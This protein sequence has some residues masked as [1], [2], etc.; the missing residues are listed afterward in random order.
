MLMKGLTDIPGIRVGHVSDFEA[1]TGCT[2]IL[3]DLG[4]GKN[5]VHPGLAM[6]EAAA[7]AASTDAVAEGSVGAGTGAT[8]G[9]LFGRARAMKG[10][11]GSYTVT[12]PG[13]VMVSALCAVN[14]VGDV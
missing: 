4:M 13:G 10:G 2:A 9:K 11:V 12:L 8:V 3:C 7:A 14:A 6:G 1:I 5:G